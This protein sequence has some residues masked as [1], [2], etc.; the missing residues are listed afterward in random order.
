MH[1]AAIRVRPSLPVFVRDPVDTF[2]REEIADDHQAAG[3]Q[4]TEHFTAYGE[5]GIEVGQ[6]VEHAVAEDAI[7][8]IRT[9]WELT[10]FGLAVRGGVKPGM[11]VLEGREAEIDADCE[12]VAGIEAVEQVA[13]VAADIENRSDI[14]FAEVQFGGYIIDH[15]GEFVF[16]GAT[17]SDP[18]R[19]G[20]PG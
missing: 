16:I 14:G 19:V 10:G 5:G 3:T 15:G 7:E 9:E 2:G 18:D 13:V 17:A 6:V 11:G 4:H 20:V 1:E 12:E 8:S